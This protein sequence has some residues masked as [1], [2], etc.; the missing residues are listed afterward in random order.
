[1]KTKT[2]WLFASLVLITMS[3]CFITS[4]SDDDDEV[5][6]TPD[7]NYSW[8]DI[9]EKFGDGEWK[10]DGDCYYEAEIEPN[11][12]AVNYWEKDD[13]GE[14]YY[15]YYNNNEH[16]IIQ[17]KVTYVKGESYMLMSPRT[18]FNP[19]VLFNRNDLPNQNYTVGTKVRFR[20]SSYMY[21]TEYL[22]PVS[23]D[24]IIPEFICKITPI[25]DEDSDK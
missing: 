2:F 11:Y 13:K 12:I 20:V 10:E 7:Y 3:T 5:I 23:P 9:V 19:S 17:A 25:I 4:C 22:K 1:M 6:P 18:L 24:R 8:N 15:N 16:E 21:N 14:E